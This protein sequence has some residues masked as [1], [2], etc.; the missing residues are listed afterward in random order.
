[1]SEIKD[2]IYGQVSGTVGKTGNAKNGPYAVIEITRDGSQYPD[3]VTVWSLKAATGDRISVKG[4]LSW[5]KNERDG[6]TYF[7]V[8]INK[9][10]V[11]K[12]EKAGPT[13]AGFDADIPF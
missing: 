8:S 6:K 13:Q 5:R 1:M 12:H 9:P 4:W 2:G 11:D 7:D 10:V 3:R